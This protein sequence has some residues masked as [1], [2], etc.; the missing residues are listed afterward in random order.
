MRSR[1]GAL[2]ELVFQP[3]RAPTRRRES[4]AVWAGGILWLC[5]VAWA[6]HLVFSVETS[7]LEAALVV[8]FVGVLAA[9]AVMVW[10]W[11][12]HALEHRL[13]ELRFRT[14]VQTAQDLIWVVDVEGRWSFV[15]EA[16]RR[17]YG[18]APQ[19]M[20]GRRYVDFLAPGR[21]EKDRAVFREILKGR[22]RH[23]ETVHVRKD[24]Q[25]VVLLYNATVVRD[26]KGRALGTMGTATDV[27]YQRR[28]QQSLLLN[29]RL[30]AVATLGGGLA[31][32][33]NNLL[34]VIIGQAQVAKAKERLPLQLERRL[35]SILDSA[36]RARKLT[37]QLV[38]F[39]RRQP[40]QKEVIDLVAVVRQMR[41]LLRGLAGDDIRLEEALP[42]EPVRVRADWGQVEQIIMNLVVNARDAIAHGGT[43][44]V[45]VK[46]RLF[47]PEE[48][49]VL[50]L[51]AR[52]W[53]VLEVSDDGVG[54][55]EG[56]RDR[57]FEPF[58]TTKEPGRGMGLGLAT[59]HS[60]VHQHRGRITVKTTP[61]DGTSMRVLLPAVPAAGAPESR[62]AE[63][64][65]A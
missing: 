47:D 45:S 61:G 5:L 36:E 6:G 63:V 18:Y 11:R 24:G 16:A 12:R 48:A 3:G 21:L 17:I 8:L 22:A 33:F 9:L 7:P 49:Q 39:A 30:R 10:R 14:L 65:F 27:T 64:A 4:L 54:M 31:H 53:A 58:F 38:A 40:L 37:E 28:M 57:I 59:V 25:H 19:E 41:G 15:N 32:D 29:E 46:R 60:V 62:D 44:T 56:T 35:N 23:H 34:T 1:N 52:D 2:E 55:D 42:D 51:D 20:I 50:R 26:D 43:V 13:K